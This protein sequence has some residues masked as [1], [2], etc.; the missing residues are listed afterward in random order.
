MTYIDPQKR[1]N[2][3]KNGSPHAREEVIAEWHALAEK[4]C[5]EL[6]RAGLPAYVQYPNTLA[7]MQAGACVYVDTVEGPAGGVHVSWNAGASL[8]E[9][10]FDF[11]QPDRLDLLEPVIAHGTRVASLMNET[12]R[13]A[14]T[15]AGFRTRDAVELNDLAPGTYVAGR[16]PRQ[17]FIEHILTEGVLGLIAAIRTWYPSDDGSGESAG[18]SAA[19]KARLT[20]RGI[21]IMRDSLHRLPDDDRLEL[22]RVFRRLAGAMHSQ[23]MASR[24]FWEA[25]RSLLELPDELC[26]LPQEPSAV[27]GG[28]VTR[29][30]MLA[31]TYIALL[32]SIELAD[33]DTVG[34]DG[35]VKITEAWTGTLL[36]RME[37]APDEDRQEL[38]RLFREAAREETDPAHKAF[39]S[40]FSKAIGLV[41]EGD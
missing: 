25:D 38:I 15:L 31:A 4:V 33:E 13:S 34:V 35:A 7:D 39:A 27:A 20:E 28:S 11:M 10:I 23:N 9:E 14:L 30:Q 1:A 22:A 40:G 26:L 12:I 29:S 41:E 16:Q 8:T 21:R 3:E 36:R 19:G 24:G 18:I 2:A 37:R 32:G 5:R 6:Q 17:W